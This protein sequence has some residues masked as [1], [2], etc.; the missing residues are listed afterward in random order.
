MSGLDD[1]FTFF[2]TPPPTDQAW[3]MDA[4]VTGTQL[5]DLHAFVATATGGAAANVKYNPGVKGTTPAS[6]SFDVTLKFQIA[7]PTPSTT[8]ITVTL[9]SNVGTIPPMGYTMKIALPWKSGFSCAANV[10]AAS[11]VVYGSQGTQFVTLVLKATTY[12]TIGPK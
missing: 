5:P 8:P 1:T 10:D 7:T 6:I 12:S 9:F 4:T 3:T 2:T 11:G